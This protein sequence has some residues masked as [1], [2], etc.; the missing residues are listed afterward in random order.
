MNDHG[1][2][3]HDGPCDHDHGAECYE[4]L[5][6]EREDG[7]LTIRLNRPSKMNALSRDLLLE[8]DCVVADAQDDAE[9]GAIVITG[10]DTGKKPSFAAG[11]DIAEMSGMSVLE[12]RAHGRLGQEVFAA[13]EE[14]C[15]PV[16]AA[17]NGFAF[18][19]GLELAMA[20][21]IRY[22]AKEATMGQPEINLGLIPGFAGTQRLA[23]I[24]GRGRALE[25]LLSGD[26]I[27][28]DEAYRLGLVNKVFDA[29]LLLLETLALAKKLAGK[30]PV[31]RMAI[32]DAV[33]RGG[34]LP[35][36]DAQALEADL[37]GM[38][39]STEDTRE[40]M[41]AFIEKRKPVWKGK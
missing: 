19:G 1:H 39:A 29:P 21:H 16:L 33:V 15:K 34:S 25:I 13:I 35:F 3:P 27:G 37:F 20:C 2:E 40:G 32:V 12:L 18:G 5:L 23:R 8:L 24:V 4:N 11:A 10:A 14:S 9:T 36:A 7:V 17:L 6:V 30:A 28:A 31:A 26:P 41:A 38:M 22:A